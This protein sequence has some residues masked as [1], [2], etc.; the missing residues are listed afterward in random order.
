MAL[1]AI[2]LLVLLSGMPPRAESQGCN[3]RPL[4]I[5]AGFTPNAF[6]NMNRNDVEAAFKV[7]A[8]T[9]G[10]RRGYKV[11][12]ETR[13]FE[14]AAAFQAAFEDGGVNLAIFDSWSYLMMEN[15]KSA[16]P[17]FVA[18]TRGEVGQR[19]LVLTRKDSGLNT[20]ADLRGKGIVRLDLPSLSIGHWWLETLLLEKRL[21]MVSTFFAQVISVAKP[22]AA[23]LPVFF[24]KN[25][26]CMVDEYAFSVMSE[27]NPQVGKTLQAVETSGLLLEALICLTHAGWPSE[28]ARRDL[29][30][31]LG[32]LHLEPAGRQILSLFKYKQLLP[33]KATY[34]DSA[35]KLRSTYEKLRKGET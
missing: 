20:L 27:L 8:Q 9:V 24:G 14:N 34:L 29:I 13:M 2:M 23:V 26:A 11:T 3:L 30:E 31:T 22:A 35:K 32:E 4:T 19:Y 12:A 1:A 33:F 17:V 16:S 7:L 15:T 6:A 28:E 21:G 25:H 10:T 5:R 18:T